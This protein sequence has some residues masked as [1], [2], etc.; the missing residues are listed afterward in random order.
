MSAPSYHEGAVCPPYA[1]LYSSVVSL[2]QKPAN[3]TDSQWQ[4]VP[5]RGAG[6]G[7]A[8]WSIEKERCF[9]SPHAK[10]D[11]SSWI[12]IT[13]SVMWSVSR[14]GSGI[15]PSD[16]G[17]LQGEVCCVCHYLVFLCNTVMLVVTSVCDAAAAWPEQ[18]D[19]RAPASASAD[20]RERSDARPS[21]AREGDD[22]A[23]TTRVPWAL[24][25]VAAETADVCA[26][27][28][29]HRRRHSKPSS[30]SMVPALASSWWQETGE[31]AS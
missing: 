21:R 6:S 28:Q 4:R 9:F 27:G 16:Y 30:L 17:W 14:P 7:E 5:K 31:P 24:P 1:R 23:T 15:V 8:A 13:V 3:V 12:F 25:S 2:L 26:L 19:K 11:G 29:S 22:L 18:S 20:D 10:D